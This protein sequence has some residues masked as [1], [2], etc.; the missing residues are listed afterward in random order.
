MK[1][2]IVL[3]SLLML[4]VLTSCSVSQQKE[5]TNSRCSFL[6]FHSSFCFIVKTIKNTC[7]LEILM[8]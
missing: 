3:L 7:F 2:A 8:I 6:P 1:K 5:P 4:F